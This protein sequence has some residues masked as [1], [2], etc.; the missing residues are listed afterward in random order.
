MSVSFIVYFF[1]INAWI[2]FNSFSKLVNKW[3]HVSEMTIYLK[4]EVHS[5]EIN[6][7][8]MFLT[9]N[10]GDKLQ[11]HLQSAEDIQK[12]ITKMMPK[13]KIDFSGSEELLSVI[14]PHFIISSTTDL[15]GKPLFELFEKISKDLN[16]FSFIESTSYG[17]SWIEKYSHILSSISQGSL[18]FLIG[19]VFTLILVIGNAIRAHIYTKRE[20]IEILELIGATSSM[21][22]RPFI[23]EGISLSSLSML[24][25][26]S[27]TFIIIELIQGIDWD[28]F[29]ILN[30]NS[31]IQNISLF[32]SFC[33][34]FLSIGIGFMGS[35]LCLI[36]INSSWKS[37]TLKKYLSSL[38]HSR[39]GLKNESQQ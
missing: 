11:T 15:V 7:L 25:A 38:F 24:T 33:W 12:N 9:N 20:E 26:L 34:L 4:P 37:G 32:D 1:S 23:L 35:Y 3:G 28:I 22:R 10:Y 31:V 14:P 27:L 16:Q 2:G 13:S 5:I 39:M 18:L 8:S 17:K 36:E 30:L 29:K 19:L 6:K 21:I